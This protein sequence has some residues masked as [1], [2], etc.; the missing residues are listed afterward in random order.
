MKDNLTHIVTLLDCSGSMAKVQNDT[1]GGFNNFIEEQKKVP[2][3][4]TMTL[5][6]FSN[7][8]NVTFSDLALDKITPLTTDTYKC[9]GW[10][11]LN[12]SLAYVINETGAKLAAKPE[13]ERPSKVIILIMTD[14][15]ENKSDNFIGLSGLQRLKDLVIHQKTK[16]SWVFS[17]M[18]ANIDS[19][20]VANRYSIDNGFAI[21]YSQNSFGQSNAFKSLSRGVAAS[22][23]KAVKIFFENE[24]NLSNV[25]S[26]KLDI[27]DIEDTINKYTNPNIPIV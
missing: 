13:S 12:D 2:G 14:G 5:V 20:E 17:F 4:A 24:L 21:N 10:T 19:F 16:Y 8:H 26:D 11:K 15:E 3:E 9:Y 18:G 6:Q 25:A 27:S 7:S 1:I 23:M 22:R